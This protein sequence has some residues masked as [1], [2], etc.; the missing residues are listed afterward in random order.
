MNRETTTGEYAND[1]RDYA[2]D[3]REDRGL[4][5]ER[6]NEAPDTAD[7]FDDE[8]FEANAVEDNAFEDEDPDALE[9]SETDERPA[10]PA[11]SDEPLLTQESAEAFL[12]RWSDVQT[13]FIEDPHKSVTEADALLADVLAA[14]QQAVEQR[15]ARIS[16]AQQDNGADTEDLRLTLLEY[17]NL[18]TTLLPAGSDSAHPQ[19]ADSPA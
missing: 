8:A 2:N 12:D 1:D 18:I 13:G 9:L 10:E 14:Q 15:R 5:E 3:D 6:E 7:A 4:V 16:A 11:S 17:R 19:K